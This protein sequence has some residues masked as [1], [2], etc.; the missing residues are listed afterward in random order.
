VAERVQASALMDECA[1]EPIHIPGCIQPHGVLLVASRDGLVRQA[2][3]NCPQLLGRAAHELL[4]SS[5]AQLPGLAAGALGGLLQ[6]LESAQTAWVRIVLDAGRGEVDAFAF[7]VDERVVLEL[8]PV[9]ASQ[10][11]SVLAYQASVQRSV[12][13]LHEA[14]D[15][16]ELSQRT[17]EEIQRLSGF[18]RVMLY[19][20]DEEWNGAVVAETRAD[21]V[22]SY[23]GQQ[24]PASDIPAQARQLFLENWLR[25]IPDATYAAVPLLPE[26]DAKGAQA[27]DLTR[28]LL[29]SAS[30]IHLEYLRNM[31]VG[32]TL[33][34]SL[35]RAGKLWGLIAC[36]H[37]VPRHASHEVRSACELLGRLASS[38]LA[39]KEQSE[40]LEYKQKLESVHSKLV[41]FMTRSDD[42]VSGLVEH[43]PNLLDLAAA[44]GAAAAIYLEGHWTLI[45]NVPSVAHI[46]A[47]AEWLSAQPPFEVFSTSSLPLVYPPAEAFKDVASGLLAVSIPKSAR[48]YVLWFRPEVVQ[49]IRWAG[50][51]E[52]SV[53]S[54][55]AGSRLHPRS[56]F[57][58]W[59]QI[60]HNTSR[61]WK[62]SELEAA[63]ELRKAIIEL[64]L[65]RQFR[66]EQRAR[67]AAEAAIQ[68]RDH[69]LAVV[70]HDLKNPLNVFRL[71]LEMLATTTAALPPE[72]HSVA[73]NVLPRMDS[74]CRRMGGLID[75]VLILAKIETGEHALESRDVLVREL[76]SDTYEMLEPLAAA[77]GIVLRVE[78]GQHGGTVFCDRERVMQVFSNLLGNAIKFTPRAGQVTLSFE[79]GRDQATFA[80]HDTGPGIPAADLPHVFDR[81][82]QAR[83]TA[84][85]GAGLGLAIAKG[86][87]EAHGGRIWVE[88]A[89]G[90]GATFSVSLPRRLAS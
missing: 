79:R 63:R 9:A 16:S 47:L 21:G 3:A 50:N 76:L 82:W 18:D 87:V 5:L 28:S 88:S 83:K 66:A 31:Q 56:S 38:L 64:D 69:V 58:L 20:F 57:A 60:V 74:A 34:V 23:L 67:A 22:D 59:K 41:E 26:R 15:L 51:P 49:T 12:T 30:P 78:G 4:G 40:D 7:V 65:Q 62:G 72:A 17:T 37:R 11:E 1:R 52:K 8:E 84:R 29:R 48:N 73:S 85:Q 43:S 71:G 54:D 44:E 10:I 36:H 35:V 75:D 14:R 68:A 24:F 2:S 89:E 55:D 70:T 33:T 81:F 90:R 45:G 61:P 77:K 19:R 80:V 42:L 86:L 32:A 46:G 6:Q 39:I 25:M 27:I 53:R 13:R